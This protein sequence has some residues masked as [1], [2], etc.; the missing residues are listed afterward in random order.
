MKH[1]IT[2][3]LILT[4]SAAHAETKTVS[5]FL[6]HPEARAKVYALCQDNPGEA[7]HTPNCFNALEASQQASNKELEKQLDAARGRTMLEDCD[8]QGWLFQAANRCGKYK[9]K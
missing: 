7:Q 6:A 3:T 2:A 1:V 4:A 5:W 9:P 8:K